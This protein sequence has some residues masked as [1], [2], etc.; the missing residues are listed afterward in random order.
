MATA[1]TRMETGP[2]QQARDVL[3]CAVAQLF[4][5]AKQNLPV[6]SS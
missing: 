6:A 2:S 1:A 3:R 4:I 5:I